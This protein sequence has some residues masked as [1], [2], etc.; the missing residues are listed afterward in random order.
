M[1]SSAH[2][3]GRFAT[4]ETIT[5]ETISKIIRTFCVRTR[6]LRVI[7]SAEYKRT[8]VSKKKIFSSEKGISKNAAHKKEP[9]SVKT[10]LTASPIKIKR[11]FSKTA[12]HTENIARLFFFVNRKTMHI[13]C[14]YL[15]IKL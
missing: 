3:S 1:P 6:K 11:Y 8:A 4:R 14:F 5:I 13:A 10:K 15:H 12:S 2:K 7:V 9:S